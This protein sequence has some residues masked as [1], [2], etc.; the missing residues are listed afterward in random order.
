MIS[1]HIKMKNK[2]NEIGIEVI[3]LQIKALRKLRSTVDQSF[4]EA[5]KA[6]VKCKSKIIICGVGKSG[7]IA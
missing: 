1:G 6:I 5:V 2:I 4:N 3:D 7:K